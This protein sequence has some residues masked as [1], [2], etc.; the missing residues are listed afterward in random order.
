MTLPKLLLNRYIDWKSNTYIK[1]KNKLRFL[2]NTGQKPKAMIISCCDS[3]VL[4]NSIFTGDIG[5]YFVH[6]NVA[7]LIH[8]YNNKKNNSTISSIEYAVKNLKIKQLIILGHSKCGGINR[9]YQLSNKKHKNNFEYLDNWL[10]ELS[11]KFKKFKFKK[12]NKNQLE[13]LEK[14]SIKM[15]IENLKKF[16]FIKRSLSMNNLKILG[17]WFEIKSGKL[18]MLNDNKNNFQDIDY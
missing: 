6:R 10:K 14:E 12:S 7:N 8:S 5:D 15:S 9:A 16:P 4:E 13:F 1:K 2:Y 11:I 18:M 3:R 17:L